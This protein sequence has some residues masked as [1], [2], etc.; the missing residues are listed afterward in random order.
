MEKRELA[1]IRELLPNEPEL[2]RLW[3]EHQKLSKELDRLEALRSLTPSETVHRSELK[4][5]KL[6]GRDRIQSILGH[7]S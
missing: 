7:R 4:K 2:A 6:A 3:D 1:Q 5:R